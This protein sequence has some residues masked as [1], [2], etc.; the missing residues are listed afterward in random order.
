MVA[1]VSSGPLVARPDRGA[2]DRLAACCGETPG[3]IRY[4]APA[5]SAEDH[6]GRA[7]GLP[8]TPKAL[9]CL[10]VHIAAWR[11]S[12]TTTAVEQLLDELVDMLEVEPS[13]PTM[14]L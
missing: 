8:P 9:R 12:R 3:R 13:A 7:P 4:G 5:L 11:N 1:S 14:S 2:A 6:P 10:A